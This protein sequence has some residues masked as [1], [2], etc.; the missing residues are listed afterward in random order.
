MTRKKRWAVA[1]IG[2]RIGLLLATVGL[3]SLCVWA[4][5]A[6]ASEITA[7]GGQSSPGQGM[8]DLPYKDL[9]IGWLLAAAIG[10]VGGVVYVGIVGPARRDHGDDEQED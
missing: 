3:V 6:T 5:P 1:F 9:L 2:T 8:L 4:A 10:A 7:G